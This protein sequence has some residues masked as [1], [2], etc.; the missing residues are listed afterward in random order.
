MTISR[1]FFSNSAV[2]RCK[3]PINGG[4]WLFYVLVSAFLPAA[5][6]AESSADILSVAVPQQLEAQHPTVQLLQQAY[7]NLGINIRL[8]A[9]P[10]ERIRRELAL[11]RLDAH[12]AA[13]ETLGEVMPELMRLEVPVYQLELAVFA[14]AGQAPIANVVLMKQQRVAYLQGMHMVEVLLKKH[15]IRQL[16]AVMS[17][18]QVLQGLEKG[19]YDTAIL[20]RREAEAV[21]KQLKLTQVVLLPPILTTIPLYHYLH[22]RHHWLVQPLTA[23]LRR[24]T[25]SQPLVP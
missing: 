13:A 4:R 7:K 11:G 20:P 14:R 10:L 22:R 3:K 5:V 18:S 15:D 9:M 25:E 2:N 24:L 12:L 16:N 23:E 19:R 1:F 8:D 21:L 6:A 17:L